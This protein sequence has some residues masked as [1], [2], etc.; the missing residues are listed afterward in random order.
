[1]KAKGYDKTYWAIDLHD[2]VIKGTYTRYNEDRKI[3][4][5]CQQ[6]F[7][8]AA[9]RKDMVLILWSSSHRDSLNEIITWLGLHGIKFHYINENPEVPSD[10]LCDFST[11]FYFN[12]LLDDKA[13]FEG[14]TDW[15][16]IINELKRIGEWNL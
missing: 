8:W 3:Y 1:M 2:V 11:K 10:Q 5:D 4:P 16:A 6:F 14:E 7:R 12:V 9:S 15:T 13:G